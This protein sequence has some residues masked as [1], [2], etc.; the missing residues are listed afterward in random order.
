MERIFVRLS[1]DCRVTFL[2]RRAIRVISAARVFLQIEALKNQLTIFAVGNFPQVKELIE[3]SIKDIFELFSDHARN[4]SFRREELCTNC[5]L[6]GW[7]SE[8]GTCTVH[9]NQKQLGICDHVPFAWLRDEQELDGVFS[10]F[11]GT[12]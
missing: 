6:L 1:K 5:F 3:V 11:P 2:S 4:A 7:K 12:R 9:E 8:Q 10:V